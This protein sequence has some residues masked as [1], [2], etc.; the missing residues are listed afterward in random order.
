MTTPMFATEEQLREYM[1]LD[2]VAAESKYSSGILTSNLRAASYMLERA[3]GRFFHDRPAATFTVTTEGAASVPLPGFRSLASVVLAG[4]ALV[5]EQG[6]WL[7]PDPS[8]TGLILGIQFR[9]YGSRSDGPSWLHYSDWFD[10]NLDSPRWPG[11]WG[12]SGGSLPGDLVLTGDGGFLDA[13]LP[14]PVRLAT[15]ALAGFLTL[16]PTG[17]LLAGAIATPAGNVFDMSAWPLEVKSFIELWRI[18]QQVISVG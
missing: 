14:E 10:R 15:K 5:A 8:G 11:N 6:Y 4:S 13:D 7:Q 1:D 18:G 3:T 2:P 12:G 16:R 9:A 17:A